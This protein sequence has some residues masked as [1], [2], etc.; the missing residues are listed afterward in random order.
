M[1][2][3]HDEPEQEQQVEPGRLSGIV[4]PFSEN[5]EIGPQH[6]ILQDRH[7]D[8]GNDRQDLDDRSS[9]CQ[10][11]QATQEVARADPASRAQ[12]D[13][14]NV[15]KLKFSCLQVGSSGVFLSINDKFT[16]EKPAQ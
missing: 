7:T 13:M 1:D 2:D 4:Q 12:Q 10:Q 8:R 9:T 11:D 14:G 6:R 5:A 16:Q 3:D 15:H